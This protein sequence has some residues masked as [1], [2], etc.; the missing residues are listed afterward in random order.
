MA[1]ALPSLIALRAFEAVARRGSVRAAAEDLNVVHGAVSRQIKVLEEQ[2]GVSLFERQGRTLALTHSG[3]RFADAVQDGFAVIERAAR[4][5][6]PT[7][8]RHPFRLG[9]MD[10]F[11]VYWLVPRLSRFAASRPGFEIEL[12]TTPVLENLDEPTL[13]AVV[14][15]GDYRPRPDMEGTRILTDDFGPVASPALIKEHGITVDPNT[16]SGTSAIVVKSQPKLWDAWFQDTGN[17]AVR[18]K[19]RIEFD[20]MVIGIEAAKAGLGV[21]IVPHPYVQ[22]LIDRGELV[23]LYGF[24][25]RTGGYHFC[26][27]ARDANTSRFAKVRAWLTAEGQASLGGQPK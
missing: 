13:D 2:L 26:C 17:R 16:M 7:Q 23:A 6:T 21:A 14:V 5:V 12:V 9:V 8:A 11:G 1:H 18:F 27:R 10:S 15:G 24:S 3:K 20:S 19:R 22:P 25:V 4:E